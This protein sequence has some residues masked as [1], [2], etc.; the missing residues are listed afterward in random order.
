ME[1]PRLLSTTRLGQTHQYRR[2]G[3]TDFLTDNDR[4]IFSSAFRRLQDKTQVFPLAETDYVR[5]RLTHSLEASNIGRT[6]GKL[7]GGK[8]LAALGVECSGPDALSE[9]DFGTVVATACLAHDIG[10]PPFGHNGEEAIREWFRTSAT[11][12]AVIEALPPDCRADFLHFEGNAQG[13]R[14]LNRLQF[15]DRV[16]GM[17]L[18]CA[19]LG[20]FMKYP[21][22]ATCMRTKDG[23]Y[24][25]F[26]LFMAERDIFAQAAD[27]LG[28]PRHNSEA[29]A[30]AR[31]PL[32]YLVEAADDI[33]Y[34]IAD[35]EDGFRRGRVTYDEVRDLLAPLFPSEGDW[36]RTTLEAMRE[37]TE[38]VEFLRAMAIGGVVQSAVACFMQHE[39]SL[40]R[41]EPLPKGISAHMS[42]SAPFAALR[43]ADFEKVYQDPQVVEIEAA[44]FEVMDT[45]LHAFGGAVFRRHTN[46][47]SARDRTLIKL[48]PAL[49][50]VPEDN[51]TPEGLYHKM[52]EVTDF[53]SG[54]TDTS[55]VSLYKKLSG[56]MLAKG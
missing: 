55:A 2:E 5:T 24:K 7:A 56:M 37:P 27:D 32:A 49:R 54:M 42:L 36:W 4:I 31:H 17:R 41:G 16:G 47:M 23:P 50:H 52:L 8:I 39:P 9:D 28:L 38:R 51:D 19:T 44:G 43:K 13:F 25:K 46:A 15:P 10:N 26:G 3:R 34:S 21:C 18:T 29:H 12:K 6:L 40:L 30:W 22:D 35:I 45:L 11:G 1:W 20:A 48:F 33:S 14:I 53:V